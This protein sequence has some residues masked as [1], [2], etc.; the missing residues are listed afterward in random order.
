MNYIKMPIAE[1]GVISRASGYKTLSVFAQNLAQII[2]R[3][4]ITKSD[5]TTMHSFTRIVS[6]G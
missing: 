1:A 2:G 3:V 5:G 4:D 6:N